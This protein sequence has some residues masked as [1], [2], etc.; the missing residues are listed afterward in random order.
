MPA[1]YLATVE[2]LATLTGLPT[3][4]PKLLLALDRASNRFRDAVGHPVHLVTDDV[5]WLD[6]DGTDTLLL[7]AAPFTTISVE[8]DGA[9][10]TDY[11]PARRSGIL[12]R[13]G[14]WPDGLE[15]IE[16]TY[17]HGYATIPG[18]IVDAVLEQ[19]EMQ[20]MVAGYVESEAAIN[21]SVKY[22]QQATVGVTQRWTDAVEKYS[23]GRG[24]RS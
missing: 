7:P 6:G 20:A 12:R 19:A 10:V 18:G 3:T 14:G 15:N 16:V 24:D 17:T 21:Q 8:V 9:P 22:G 11:K 1:P 13:A 2:Q 23:L 4:S 5:I